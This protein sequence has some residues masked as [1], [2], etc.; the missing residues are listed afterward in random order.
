MKKIVFMLLVIIALTSVPLIGCS[1]NPQTTTLTATTSAPSATTTAPITKTTAP[2]ATTT[3]LDP[4]KYGGVYIM[5][6]SVGLARPIGYPSEANGDS[7]TCASPSNENLISVDLKGN[8]IPKLAVSWEVAPNGSM[9]LGLRK[10]VKFHDGSDF[11]AKVAK[12]NLDLQIEAKKTTNWTSVDIIDDYTIRI[13]VVEYKNTL[14][15]GL[16]SGIT[17]MVSKEYVEKNGVEAARWHPVGTGP[18]IFSSYDRDSKLTYKR[19]PN[20]WDPGKP[21]LDGIQYVVLS[22]PTIRKLAFQKGDIHETSG[23]GLDA[24]ELQKAG[25]K[26]YSQPGGTFALLPDSKNNDSPWSNLNVRLAASYSLDRESFSS[27]L[28]YGFTNPAY[29]VYPGFEQVALPNLDKHLYDK[30]RAKNLLKEAGYPSG[31]K[32]TMY[33]FG[34]VVPANYPTALADMLRA[35][36]INIEVETPTAGKYDEYRYAGWHN[37]LMNHALA[38]YSNYSSMGQYWTGLQFPS[39][40][41]PAGFTEGDRAAATSKEPQKELIQALV[42]IMYDDVMV[43]PYIEETKIS[44]LGKGVHN[45]DKALFDLTYMLVTNA[46]LEPSARK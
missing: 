13:N 16:A 11:N 21:Y 33:V 10:G 46:W 27:A 37:A 3:A 39:V 8:I 2:T 4:A 17:Q 23:S 41:L 28:G 34:R 5:A 26:M 24:Q 9:I 45:D 30:T 1:D 14:L 43:I 22:D 25:Y 44:F 20:Y 38:N 36:G 29:Q 6:I 7:Y 32:T 40:K 19:N 42:R 35:V 18:F 15:T 12:W 31:F